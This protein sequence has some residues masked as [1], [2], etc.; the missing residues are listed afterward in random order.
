ML[1]TRSQE[2]IDHESGLRESSNRF[3]DS[4]VEILHL[5]VKLFAQLWR[6]F[7]LE[8]LNLESSAI[9]AHNSPGQK[10]LDLKSLLVGHA[11]AETVRK[12]KFDLQINLVGLKPFK[13]K[14]S[15]SD[16]IRVWLIAV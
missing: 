10:K 9:Y 12:H 7:C 4:V 15:N 13:V 3:I 1:E 16:L 6:N 14:R 5:F 2:H 8:L 11:D